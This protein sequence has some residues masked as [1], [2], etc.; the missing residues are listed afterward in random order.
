MSL[1]VEEDKL[2]AKTVT[3]LASSTS[4]VPT[5][6]SGAKTDIKTPPYV[7]K[8][9]FLSRLAPIKKEMTNHD[10]FEAK[11]LKELCINKRKIQEH[12]E[13]FLSEET[14]AVLQRKLPPKLK[15]LSS[16]TIPCIIGNKKC[17]KALLDLG[18]SVNR[19]PHSIYKALNL[20]ELQDTMGSIQLADR[21]ITYPIDVI[22][23]GLI[24]VESFVIPADFLILDMKEDVIR[25]KE[26]PLILGRPFVA[27]TDTINNV[28]KGIMTMTVFDETIEFKN[29]KAMKSPNN[30]QDCFWVDVVQGLVMNEIKNTSFPDSLEACLVEKKNKDAEIV[31]YKTNQMLDVML[32]TP[33][34]W[35]PNLTTNH[36]NAKHQ[37]C[38]IHSI[39]TESEIE[40][41]SSHLKDHKMT[42]G[43]TIADIKR[44]S[45]S[46]CMHQIL[47]E[48]EAKPS[49][50][51]QR[52]VQV[53][54]KKLGITVVKNEDNELIPTITVTGWR[55]DG[56]SAPSQGF[57]HDVENVLTQPTKNSNDD[58][59]YDLENFNDGLDNIDDVDTSLNIK[60]SIQDKAKR[61][62]DGKRPTVGE[63]V[64]K[65][66]DSI[67]RGCIQLRF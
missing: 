13:V 18:V 8:P 44:I 9:P 63:K 52:L 15:D 14:S 42:I 3:E 61:K 43:W 22:E 35:R 64:I 54:P 51:G 65:R 34:R 27:T 62:R 59:V 67:L 38:T 16:F 46:M 19:M 60:T 41:I 2:K 21:S 6:F 48:D 1:Q 29:F 23:D 30:I 57:I 12:S 39:S 20:G 11:F 45:P 36:F 17:E 66:L 33:Y 4:M 55:G 58:D 25:G 24:K 26:L 37:A 50:E 5:P 7:L 31:N 47:L 10:I 56:A 28:K 49:R 40:V 32:Y 53:V